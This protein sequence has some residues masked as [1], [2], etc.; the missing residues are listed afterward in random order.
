M[1]KEAFE[2]KY[3]LVAKEY[4]PEVMES[5]KRCY[6]PFELRPT[7]FKE[8]NEYHM[9]TLSQARD[10]LRDFFHCMQLCY[11]GYNFFLSDESC[12][13]MEEELVKKIARRPIKR[14]SNVQLCRYLYRALRKAVTENHF[15]LYVRGVNYRFERLLLMYVSDLVVKQTSEGYEVVKGNRFFKIGDVFTQAQVSEYLL[16]TLCPEFMDGDDRFFLLGVSSYAPVKNIH[17]AGRKLPVHQILADRAR[18]QKSEKNLEDKGG[19]MVVNHPSYEL[20]CSQEM[21]EAFK[22]DGQSCS[23]KQAT[24]LNL[25]GNVGGNSYFP[26]CFFEGLTGSDYCEIMTATF[27]HPQELTKAERQYR[28]AVPYA[29]TPRGHY[30]GQLFVAMNKG[31]ASSAEN[32]IGTARQVPGA[33]F[34]GSPSRGCGTFGDCCVYSLPNSKIAFCFGYKILHYDDCEEGRGFLP[35]YWIDDE[36]PVRVVEEYLRLNKNRLSK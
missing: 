24:I 21:F 32:G 3:K 35:D 16:P 29:E 25:T 19:Y 5:V 23:E 20:E 28:I 36:D 31:T 12:R 26:D 8:S 2:K 9:I 6:K 30:G 17:I 14:I 34:V 22:A 13:L 11:S 33:V 18:Q 10:D 15:C 7:V 27:T 1:E 4:P